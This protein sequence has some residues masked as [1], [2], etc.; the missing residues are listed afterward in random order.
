MELLS[1]GS[2][3][4]RMA[5]HCCASSGS[6]W[7]TEAGPPRAANRS[8]SL[9]ASRAACQMEKQNTTVKYKVT[10]FDENERK[11]NRFSIFNT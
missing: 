9:M 4:M 8:S 10:K 3:D 5:W 11:K 7:I 1:L 6:T 2:M